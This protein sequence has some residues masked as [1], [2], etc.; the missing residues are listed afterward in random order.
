M[1]GTAERH[2]EKPRDR[3]EPVAVLIGQLTQ[4]GSERQLF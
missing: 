2:R 4:G 3:P 1:P